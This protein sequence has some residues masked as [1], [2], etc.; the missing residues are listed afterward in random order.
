MLRGLRNRDRGAKLRCCGWSAQPIGV[1][2][3]G[4]PANRVAVVGDL[5]P[6]RAIPLEHAD[7]EVVLTGS[8]DGNGKRRVSRLYTGIAVNLSG[9]ANRLIEICDRCL[10]LDDDKRLH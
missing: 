5:T 3:I 8:R 6:S 10:R 7:S 1:D 9:L 4:Y 2:P